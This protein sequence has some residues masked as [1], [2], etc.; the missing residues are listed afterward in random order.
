[1]GNVRVWE[2]RIL[3]RGFKREW[4]QDARNVAGGDRC[5]GFALGLCATALSFT[6]FLPG[7]AISGDGIK[8]T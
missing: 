3:R 8:A 4:F 5:S 7:Y 6:C 1:M 2:M